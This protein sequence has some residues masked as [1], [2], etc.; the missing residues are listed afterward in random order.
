[1]K[2]TSEKKHW[3]D[4]WE[5]SRDLDEVYSND[6]RIIAHL[7]QVI[8]FDGLKVLEVGAGSGRDSD[9]IAAR[10]GIVYTLDYSE[11]AL[12]LM[13]TSLKSEIGIVCGD[14][15]AVP[16]AEGSLDVVF[17]QGLLEHFRDP[18]TLVRENHRILK[19]GGLLLIDVPQRLHYY[20]L[21]KHIL[22]I[23]GKWFAGWET[24]FSPGQLREL[25][26]AEGFEIV[27][28]YGENLY[29]PIWY[30]GLR[31]VLRKFG[32]KLPMYPLP[33]TGLRRTLKNMMP[34]G[35]R[36]NT[37]MIVGCIARKV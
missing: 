22:M 9:D 34:Q 36:L 14:A 27:A 13:R 8:D 6:G 25:I 35:I 37:S 20:T 33:L 4:Y 5:A 28:M 10:G 19:T 32:V 3:D 18:E 15:K 7:G 26:R 2:Q 30:R 29:P 31:R 17:H 23:L 11:E 21:L 1:M 12:D 24:E 16:F